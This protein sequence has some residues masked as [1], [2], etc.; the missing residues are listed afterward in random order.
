MTVVTVVVVVHAVIA[1]IE[2]E[3]GRGVAAVVVRRRTP[4]VTAASS[5]VERRPV[6]AARS[7]KEDA[8]AVWSCNFIAVNAVLCRPCPCTII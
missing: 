8:V 2:V 1:T 5:A 7:R 4:I 3:V 6:T